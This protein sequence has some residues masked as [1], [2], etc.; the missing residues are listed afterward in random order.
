M[1]C[2][3]TLSCWDTG[4]G[5]VA[6]VVSGGL[7]GRWTLV[8]E[9]GVDVQSTFT[10]A[11]GFSSSALIM[12]RRSLCRVINDQPVVSSP[13]DRIFAGIYARAREKDAEEKRHPARYG[14]GII[15]LRVLQAGYRCTSRLPARKHNRHKRTLPTMS[16]TI[17]PPHA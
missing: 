12:A 13:R 3:I 7:V 4:E 6:I 17:P 14:V 2:I 15:L 10:S 8:V 9:G 1:L 16:Q 11:N 5:R